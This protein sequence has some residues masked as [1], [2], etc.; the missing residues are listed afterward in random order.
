[1]I[2]DDHAG[3]AV[4]ARKGRVFGRQ[5]ALDEERQLRIGR[6]PFEVRPRERRRDLVEDL[7]RCQA[8]AAERRDADL[9]RDRERRAQ[10][11]L[12]IPPDRRVDRKH[13]RRETTVARLCDQF[14]E[15][16]LAQ[17]AVEV[18][19]VEEGGHVG[20]GLACGWRQNSPVYS[21]KMETDDGQ[22]VGLL[23]IIGFGQGRSQMFIHKVVGH[24][25]VRTRFE[26]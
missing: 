4:L 6:D 25:A 15:R 2:R 23:S 5:H 18:R 21:P 3:G 7:L 22:P 10:V 14:R 26:E 16:A 20:L 9:G 11:A 1:M 24:R 19:L 12:A 17:I 13:E 8:A